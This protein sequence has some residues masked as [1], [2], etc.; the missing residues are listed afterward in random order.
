MNL[1]EIV[2]HEKIINNFKNAIINGQI[3]HS[4]IFE[5]P[6]S[7]G[8]KTI[9]TALAKTLL[10]EKKLTEACGI[11]GSCVQFEHENQP[12]FKII[13]NLENT[14]KKSDIQELQKDIKIKPFKGNRKVYIVC[15][16]ENM[17]AEAQNSFLKTLEEPP[18]FAI[19]ILTTEN[20]EKLLPT[21]IS[22]CQL[23]AFNYVDITKI[24]NMLVNKFNNTSEQASFISNFSNGVVGRA[25][26][27][28]ESE[29][30]EELRE[31][32]L[33]AIDTTITQSKEKIF[34]T[35]EFFEKNKDDINEILNIMLFYFRDL[36]IYSETNSSRHIINKDKIELIT[37]HYNHIEKSALHDII[38]TVLSTKENIDLK[39]SFSL[40]IELMLLEI[41]EGI[42]WQL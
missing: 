30:F 25:I 9:A 31:Q 10:C 5:G 21:I 35:S 15:Q 39:V 16:A 32:T 8:K 6:K 1:D 38:D 14:I 22:R 24:E 42:I 36:I 41:Q 26:L 27:L 23:V 20:K 29:E 28:S 17:T 13:D 19:I 7:I 34:T 37:T 2:G 3:A 40:N 11:C 33:K 12:D 4:Y 18:D